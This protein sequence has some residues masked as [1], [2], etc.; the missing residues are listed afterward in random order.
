MKKLN[1]LWM[2]GLLMFAAV[3]LCACSDDDEDN[4]GNSDLVGTWQILTDKGWDKINGEIEYEWDQKGDELGDQMGTVVFKEDGSFYI[5]DQYGNIEL[6]EGVDFTWSYRD[7]K[8]FLYAVQYKMEQ[9][10]ATVKELTSSFLAV[11]SYYK[12]E[13]GGDVYETWSYSTLKKI[14]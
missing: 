11:E 10:W 1:Y 5:Y 9:E 2:L 12:Y 7:G 3:N 13:E 6:E 4:P 14:E 8:I